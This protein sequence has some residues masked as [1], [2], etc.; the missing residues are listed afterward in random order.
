MTE[1][2]IERW[3]EGRIGWHEPG[4][5]AKLREYWPD[6][7]DSSRVLVPFCGKSR[8]IL[9]L[10]SRGLEVVGVELSQIAVETFFDEHS[11]EV[12]VTGG[13]DTIC[14]RARTHPITIICGDYFDFEAKPFDALFDRGALVA[15]PADM[16]P[17]YVEH[18]DTLLKE[19]A[20]RLVITLEYDQSAAPGPP[21]AVMPDEIATYWSDLVVLSRHNDIENCPPKFKAA[22]LTEVIETAWSSRL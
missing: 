4:G 13:G 17:R 15:V 7:A 6:M 10:A 20:Y 1:P 8:D 9:W 22:G 5:N 2:W 18:T 11:L 12:E 19:N 3:K 21:F 16:R 14:Y